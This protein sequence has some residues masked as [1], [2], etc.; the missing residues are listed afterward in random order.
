LPFTVLFSYL[1]LSARCSK[2]V[3]ASVMLVCIG[4]FWG[5]SGE[6]LKGS[7]LGISLGVLSSITTSVQWV[8][9][10]TLRSEAY[11]T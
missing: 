1:L 6:S 8:F 3:L 10:W 2:P 11:M 7:T 9:A 5:V 4:F